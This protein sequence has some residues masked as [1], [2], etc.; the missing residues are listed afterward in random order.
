MTGR[1]K[2]LLVALAKMVD[3]YLDCYQD[4]VDSRSMSAGEH[5]IG[6]LAEFGLMDVINARFGRW[7]EA[8]KKFVAETQLG[9]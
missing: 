7:T 4:E 6:A 8:G 3:Q 9:H 2:K 5:A 1:E